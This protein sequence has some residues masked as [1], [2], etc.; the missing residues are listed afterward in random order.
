MGRVAEFVPGKPLTVDQVRMLE[1]D[2]VVSEQA[3]AEER[4]LPG[5]GITPTAAE[6]VLPTYL[7]MFREQGQFTRPHAI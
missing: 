1:L 4:T 6:I 7:T 5:I 3:V 2:N